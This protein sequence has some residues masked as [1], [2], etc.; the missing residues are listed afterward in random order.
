M[1]TKPMIIGAH[2]RDETIE[3]DPLDDADYTIVC[4]GEEDI[5]YG[6]CCYCADEYDTLHLRDKHEVEC[7]FGPKLVI[8]IK[9][10][11]S[12]EELLKSKLQQCTSAEEGKPKIVIQ[13]GKRLGTKNK[14]RKKLLI[15]KCSVCDYKTNLMGHYTRH[16]KSHYPD[17]LCPGCDK[18]FRSKGVL[19][20]HVIRQ[21]GD[22][23][24]LVKTIT[25]SPLFVCSFALC[26]KRRCPATVCDNIKVKCRAVECSEGFIEKRHPSCADVVHFVIN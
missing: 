7:T 3:H 23:D 24:K 17:I 2:I 9:V 11:R 19:D 16:F 20:E 15:H 18:K 8:K 6:C 1:E 4:A 21:H 25:S 22:D 13:N 14:R 10:D 12:I 26:R 5:D